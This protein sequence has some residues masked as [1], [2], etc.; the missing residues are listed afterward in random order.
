ME[1]VVGHSEEGC[2]ANPD[3]QAE[4]W[5]R[6]GNRCN[7]CGSRAKLTLKMIVPEEAGGQ[8]SPDNAYIICRACEIATDAHRSKMQHAD[9]RPINF[10]VSRRLFERMSNGLC[11]DRGFKSKSAL[12]RYL[13]GRYLQSEKQFDDLEQYQ[14]VEGVDDVKI[15][16]WVP[17]ATYDT[18]KIMLDRRGMSVTEALKALVMV[19]ESEKDRDDQRSV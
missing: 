1:I 9:N 11:S 15:N 2:A 18:F 14:D 7:G 4:V 6:T 8:L 10:W 19:Y 3:W 5:R 12:I 13:M 16:A 17:K